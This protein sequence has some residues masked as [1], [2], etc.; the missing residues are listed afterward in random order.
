MTVPGEISGP[1]D[2]VND[3]AAPA[4]AAR[5]IVG[6]HLGRGGKRGGNVVN[7]RD[8]HLEEAE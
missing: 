3:G 1:G 5:C 6:A 4:A 8:I 7:D 2:K